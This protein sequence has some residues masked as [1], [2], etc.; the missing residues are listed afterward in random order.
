M[1]TYALPA[2]K[3]EP[4]A[5]IAYR[6][7]LILLE[8]HARGNGGYISFPECRRVLSHLYHLSKDEVFVFLGE[9]EEQGLCRIIPYHGVKINREER[10]MIL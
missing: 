9:M 7:A 5:G 8:R 1:N 10:G 3:D 6:K 2:N 4:T